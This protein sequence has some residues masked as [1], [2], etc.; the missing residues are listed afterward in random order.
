MTASLVLPE[1]VRRRTI[2]RLEQAREAFGG[3]E[4][5]VFLAYHSLEIKEVLYPGDLHH[6]IGDQAFARYE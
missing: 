1:T 5:E 3:V 2:L 6:R 4:V